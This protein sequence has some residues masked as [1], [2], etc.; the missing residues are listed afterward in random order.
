VKRYSV[1][2]FEDVGG[3]QPW[4]EGGWTGREV[5]SRQGLSLAARVVIAD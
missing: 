4:F 5:S 3:V 1:E 2:M